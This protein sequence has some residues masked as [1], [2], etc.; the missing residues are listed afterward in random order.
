MSKAL[1]EYQTG[2]PVVI[3]QIDHLTCTEIYLAV[4]CPAWGLDRFEF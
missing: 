3:E 4:V 2:S 1:S